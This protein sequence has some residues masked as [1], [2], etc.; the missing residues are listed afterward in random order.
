MTTPA[1]GS[2]IAHAQH[3][4]ATGSLGTNPYLA[5]GRRVLRRVGQQVGHHLADSGR[6]DPNRQTLPRY[7][8]RQ[9]VRPLPSVSI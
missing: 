6:V 3:D 9:N 4:L 8:D 2:R 5:A 7:L 1:A